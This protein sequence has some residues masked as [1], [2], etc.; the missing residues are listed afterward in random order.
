MANF[1]DLCFDGA[2]G[3]N[4]CTTYF[5]RTKI[6]HDYWYPF[7]TIK[8]WWSACVSDDACHSNKA[9][10]FDVLILLQP[11]CRHYT[12]FRPC[13]HIYQKWQKCIKWN[14]FTHSY[15]NFYSVNIVSFKSVIPVCFQTMCSITTLFRKWKI[16]SSAVETKLH[17]ISRQNICSTFKIVET[18][19][20]IKIKWM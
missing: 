2:V 11:W 18:F 1:F 7:R 12:S 5:T 3:I 19:L 8:P 15:L 10:L 4:T 20:K 17:I 14:T 6:K 9:F 16:L 13:S